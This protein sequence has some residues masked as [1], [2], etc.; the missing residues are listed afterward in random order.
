MRGSVLTVQHAAV[1]VD[2]VFQMLRLLC[3]DFPLGIVMDAMSS[4]Q[5]DVHPTG[6]T[7]PS[8]IHAAPLVTA[9]VPFPRL[10]D[11]TLCWVLYNGAPVLEDG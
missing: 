2:D 5:D 8:G 1:A 3:P 6:G 10:R 9:T 4:L 11:A 7:V